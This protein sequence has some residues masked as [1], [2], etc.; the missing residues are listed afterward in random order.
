MCGIAG[1][2]RFNKNKSLPYSPVVLELLKHR[3]PNAQR[4]MAFEDAV[5]YHTRLSIIDLSEQSHQPYLLNN[6]KCLVYNGEIFNYKELAKNIE[7]THTSGDTE[8]LIKF[9][10]KYKIKGLHQLNGFFSFAFYDH[11]Q[12]ELYVVRDRYGEKPLYYY[13]DKDVFAFASEIQPLLELIQKK[14]PI[15]KE[16]LYTYFRLHYIPGEYSILQGIQRLLPGYFIHIQNNTITIQPWYQL[17]KESFHEK[18]SFDELLNDA[19]KKRLISDAPL[20]AFLSGG[21]DSSIVCALAK[22]HLNTLHTFSLGY[23]HTHQY[24]ETKDAQIVAK[25]IGSTHHNFEIDIEEILDYIPNI[26]QAIDEP[27]ADSSSVNVYFLSQKI[28]PYATAVLSGDGADELLMGYNKHKIFLSHQ[29]PLLRFLSGLFYPFVSILPESR[30][31]KY[32]NTIRKIKKFM[33]A[34]TLPSV[35]KYIYLSQWANDSYIHRLFTTSLN[36]QYFYSLF[37]K[38]KNLEEAE[39]FNRADMEIVLSNDMLYKIDFFGM[40][41]A[42]EIRSP[43]LDHRVVEYLYHSDIKNKI[44]KQQKVLLRKTFSHLLPPSVFQKKKSGFEVPLHKILW[45]VPSIQILISKEYVEHQKLFHYDQIDQLKKDLKTNIHDAALKLW[46][47]VV[48]QMWYKKFEKYIDTST[49]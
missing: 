9:F 39:L 31:I 3:G 41:N 19:V 13:Y 21:V 25:H 18:V 14:L 46:T 17:Q 35:Q 11:I 28:K 8:V 26:L 16:V 33:Q 1:I 44:D 30:S 2:Y 7:N 22:R 20:G 23:K 24:N 32:F 4:Y 34:S 36:A 42:V 15:N 43:F 49:L 48:F 5:F 27:F 40:Q 38:Y 10:D 29:Y 6:E 37:E 47:V 12:K 45:N